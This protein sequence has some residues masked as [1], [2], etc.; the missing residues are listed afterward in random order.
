MCDELK[1]CFTCECFNGALDFV[2]AIAYRYKTS[3]FNFSLSQLPFNF[4]RLAIKTLHFK[5]IQ[6]IIFQKFSNKKY[7]LSKSYQHF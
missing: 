3:Y 7:V 4:Y 2:Y 5:T 1:L 6:A